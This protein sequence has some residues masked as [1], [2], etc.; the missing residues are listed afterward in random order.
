MGSK[1]RI[2][3]DRFFSHVSKEDPLTT[4]KKK[5]SGRQDLLAS[6]SDEEDVTHTV[7]KEEYIG[8]PVK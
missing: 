5:F 6:D 2:R 7:K 3:G 1:K 8:S 4:K